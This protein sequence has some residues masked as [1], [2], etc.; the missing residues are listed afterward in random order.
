MTHDINL[1]QAFNIGLKGIEQALKMSLPVSISVMDPHGSQIFF[2]KMDNALPVSAIMAPKKAK[3]CVY[4][5]MPSCEAGKVIEASLKGLD[6]SM[7]GE[8][9]AFG[10]GLP[11]FKNNRLIGAIGVSGGSV[12]EDVIIAKA[13]IK[14]I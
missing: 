12:E 6:I 5:R 2:C 1:E 13:A 3:T 11:I 14:D 7:Q 10:G 4:L 8:I 9:A